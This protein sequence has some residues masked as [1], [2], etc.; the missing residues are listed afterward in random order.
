MREINLLPQEF[1][2]KASFVKLA[3]TL[4]KIAIVSIFLLLISTFFLLVT[5]IFYSQKTKSLLTEKNELTKIIKALEDSEQR[6]VLVKDR[7][8]KIRKVQEIPSAVE[9]VEVISGVSASLPQSI[10]LKNASLSQDKVEL[11]LNGTSLIDMTNFFAS[12]IS[13]QNLKFVKIISFNFN[14]ETGY[15]TQIQ[16]QR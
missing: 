13:N 7:V 12:L 11:S 14:S 5:F 15:T 1:R 4:N 3:K 6:V 8:E 9:E 2:P 16:I 10:V